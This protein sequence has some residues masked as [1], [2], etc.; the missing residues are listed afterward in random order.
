MKRTILAT[1]LIT[2]SLLSAN[3]T[4][5]KTISSDFTQIITNSTHNT[6]KYQGTM[7]A[8]KKNNLALWIYTIPIEKEIYYRNGNIVIL[9][10]D[11]EQ[12]TFAKLNK[13]PNIITILKTAK[14]V[15]QNKLIANFNKTKYT[16]LLDKDKIKSISYKDQMQNNVTINLN[17][18]KINKEIKDNRFIYEIPAGYDII[19]Q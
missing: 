18:V 2:S 12:A 8:K 9:E 17:K 7:F 4:N 11:L 15:S 5:L 16:I 6:I 10:P 1:L 19:K 14:K 3:L 13:I